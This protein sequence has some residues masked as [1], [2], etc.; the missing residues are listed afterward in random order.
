[1]TDRAGAAPVGIGLQKRLK[2]AEPFAGHHFRIGEC[3]PAGR[4]REHDVMPV[5]P[6]RAP[7]DVAFRRIEIAVR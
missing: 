5:I 3:C 2:D 1:M 6:H 7:G 4:R